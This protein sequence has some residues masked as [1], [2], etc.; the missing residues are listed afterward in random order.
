MPIRPYLEG[1]VFDQEDI[2]TMSL[3]LEEVCRVLRIGAD[4]ARDREVVAI[5]IIELARRGE[6]EYR[7]LVERVLKEAGVD[8]ARPPSLGMASEVTAL[9]PRD[10]AVLPGLALLRTIRG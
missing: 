2:Q 8:W 3:A 1:A 4:A 9:V 10:G 6:L 5:R 7:R